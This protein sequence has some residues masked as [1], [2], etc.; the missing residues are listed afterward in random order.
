MK[1]RHHTPH[2]NFIKEISKIT[3]PIA[4]QVQISYP[5]VS[6]DLGS[7]LKGGSNM[8]T[9]VTGQASHSLE[10]ATSSL[11][12]PL[13]IAAVVAVGFLIYKNK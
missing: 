4:H 2:I 13:A 8:V 11:A 7:V 1:H 6:H 5:K 12:I 10:S 9:T 3:K